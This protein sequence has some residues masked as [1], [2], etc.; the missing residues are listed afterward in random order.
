M[1]GPV[2]EKCH[3]QVQMTEGDFKFSPILCISPQSQHRESRLAA[4][5]LVEGQG[6]T[7]LA[8]HLHTPWPLCWT[9]AIPREPKAEEDTGGKRG[10]GSWDQ[11]GTGSSK[12]RPGG[13]GEDGENEVVPLP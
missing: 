9:G 12:Q 11:L 13:G 5:P 2:H 3:I 1:L 4:A 8:V 10:H 7:A 6:D